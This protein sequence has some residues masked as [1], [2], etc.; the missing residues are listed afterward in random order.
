MQDHY[1]DGIM[2]F[3]SSGQG[4]ASI[5]DLLED[6]SMSEGSKQIWLEF[7][8]LYYNEISRDLF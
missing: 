1:I 4:I 3:R 5:L 6:I 2:L 8:D 7:S